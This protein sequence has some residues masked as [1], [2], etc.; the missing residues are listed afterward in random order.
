MRFILYLILINSIVSSCLEQSE[1]DSYA[2]S[3]DKE[4]KLG[5]LQISRKSESSPPCETLYYSKNNKINKIVI[6]CGDVSIDMSETS[7]YFN[8]ELILYI[9]KLTHYNVPPD[10]EEYD[11]TRT[12]IEI[13]K[14]YFAK[15]RM[16]KWIKPDKS[17]IANKSKE[18]ITKEKEILSELKE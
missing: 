15:G 13:E 10:S 12:K 16:T 17:E 1:I 2:F 14:C 18:F 11:S 5:Q 3:I 4:I 7:F 6:G 8:D 9:E